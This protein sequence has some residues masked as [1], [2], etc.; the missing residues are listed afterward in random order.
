MQQSKQE[1]YTTPFTMNTKIDN[2]AWHNKQNQ[3]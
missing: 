1:T 3:L 2:K